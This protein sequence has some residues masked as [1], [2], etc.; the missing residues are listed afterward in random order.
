MEE[1]VLEIG[2][3]PEIA[4]ESQGKLY[5]KGW[6]KPEVRA[7]AS[8]K[9]NLHVSKE[10]NKA[11]VR[12]LSNCEIKIPYESSLTILTASGE[13]FIKSLAAPLTVQ[14]AAANL[15]LNDVCD[16]LIE[17]VAR[18]VN[19]REINGNLTIRHADR[20]VNASYVTGD[21]TAEF[22]GAHLT[23][24]QA[25]GNVHVH[26]QGNATLN[27]NPQ[28]GKQYS[29][30]T[31]GILTCHLPEEAD[32]KINLKSEGPIIVKMGGKITTNLE[33]TYQL[34]LGEGSS[35]LD[36]TAGGSI[37]LLAS[38]AG[39]EQKT[40]HFDPDFDLDMDTLAENITRQVQ[41]QLSMQ[42]G[43]LDAQMDMLINTAGISEEKA[44]RI[45]KRTLDHIARAQQKIE[46]A[47]ERAALKIELARKKAEKT[48]P[49]KPGKETVREIQEGLAAAREVVSLVLGGSRKAREE[50]EKVSEEERLM[51]LNM[52][53]EKKITAEEAE[54]L[55]AALEGQTE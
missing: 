10:A 24:N 17:F 48:K 32:V 26:A 25:Q 20:F 15:T 39:F 40:H 28:P 47:Q 5:I 2:L 8:G 41:E 22:I 45:R 44:E 30:E 27:L 55:L 14:Q 38:D 43:L 11:V 42:M 7:S 12:C 9:G 46:R 4:V 19:A 35:A 18:D 13:T 31:N 1:I 21:F 54:T 16:A 29:L 50:R 37:S 3:T 52:L 6:D 53:A 34:T 49:G 23:L 36:L 51:I 33:H